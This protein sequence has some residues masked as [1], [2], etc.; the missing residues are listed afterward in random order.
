MSGCRVELQKFLVEVLVVLHDGGLVTTPVAVVGRA[1]NSHHVA[2]VRPIV[3]IHDE[4]VSAGNSVQFVCVVELLRDVLPKNV[5][6]AA[7]RDAP[8]ASIV[9]IGP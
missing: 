7:R 2:V 8:T 4:L 9:G 6:C 3:P 5:S 1:E